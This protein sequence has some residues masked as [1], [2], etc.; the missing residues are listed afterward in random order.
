MLVPHHEFFL[1]VFGVASEDDS[2]DKVP[3]AAS[4]S[5]RLL[6]AADAS[7]RLSYPRTTNSALGLGF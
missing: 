7:F 2:F 6:T 1:V 3:P 4:G 5:R